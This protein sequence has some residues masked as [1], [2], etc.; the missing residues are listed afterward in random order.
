ML[1]ANIDFFTFFFWIKIQ[2]KFLL[3]GNDIPQSNRLLKCTDLK[4]KYLHKKIWI[5]IVWKSKIRHS[6]DWFVYYFIF[7]LSERARVQYFIIIVK[8]FV[9]FHLNFGFF[10]FFFLFFAILFGCGGFT[11]QQKKNKKFQSMSI[12]KKI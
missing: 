12:G 9:C 11:H 10:F 5:G 6:K 3:F 8:F 1:E 7:F 2:W 4:C